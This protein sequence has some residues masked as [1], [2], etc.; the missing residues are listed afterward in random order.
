MKKILLGLSLINLTLFANTVPLHV[1]LNIYSNQ[2]FLNKEFQLKA[3]G[4]LDIKVPAYTELSDVK[5]QVPKTCTIDE[6]ILSKVKK[7]VD[8]ILENLYKKKNNLSYQVEAIYAKNELLKTLSVENISDFTKI[9][10][11]SEFLSQNLIKNF[12][13]LEELKEKITAVDKKIVEQE[14]PSSEYKDLT[15]TY[16]CNKDNEKISINY[17]QKDIKQNSFYSIDANINNKSVLIEKTVNIL[18]NGVENY[19]QIDINIY[20]YGYNQNVAPTKFYPN[21]IGGKEV[22]AYA[23]TTSLDM[24]NKT[25]MKRSDVI[26]KELDTKSFYHIKNAQLLVGKNNLIHV[27]KQIIDA[28][29]TSMI[30]AYGSNKAYLQ[31]TIYTKKDYSEGIAKLSLNSNPIASNYIQKIQ[32]GKET[33]LYFGE[34]EHIQVKKE[35][36]KTIDEKTFFGDK[37]IST[38]NW[39]YTITSKKPYSA[40]ISFIHRLPVSKNADIEVKALTQ[41]A[42]DFKDANGKIGW[43]FTL[44]QNQDKK[45]IFGYQISNSN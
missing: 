15:L 6:S 21:Y 12:S 8:P 26:H 42:A 9:D 38:Q 34:D 28:D 13:Q 44:N 33:N 25:I 39:E 27:D 4:Y 19:P 43:K 45:I 36:I 17:P 23:K 24:V 18:Y 1:D 3:Y 32:K 29:F 20:S 10:K 2:V 41:P 31:A 5:Y 11:T 40:N 22:V 14:N 30:D 7:A 37:S 35:L 16:T